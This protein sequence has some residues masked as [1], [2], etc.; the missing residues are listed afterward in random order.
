MFILPLL[1]LGPSVAEVIGETT[2]APLPPPTTGEG[3]L[4]T[5]VRC[6]WCN[7]TVLRAPPRKPCCMSVGGFNPEVLG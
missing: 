2:T 1:I 5:C 4:C 3:V 6:V 7:P